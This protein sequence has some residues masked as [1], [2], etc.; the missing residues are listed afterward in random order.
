[1]HYIRGSYDLAIDNYSRAIKLSPT[2]AWAYLHRG[3]CY[4]NK[5]ALDKAQADYNQALLLNPDFAAAYVGLGNIHYDR[6]EYEQSVI[7]N[8]KA[9][10]LNPNYGRAYR[11]RSVAYKK[12]GEFKL[13]ADDKKIV[14]KLGDKIEKL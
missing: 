6:Q 7:A 12:L 14:D 10:Q 2:Y 11:N 5:G 1:M 4:R 3:M 8:T 9:I 13:A